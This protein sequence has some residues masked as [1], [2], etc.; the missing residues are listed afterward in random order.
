M[1][2]SKFK[3][4][5]VFS[6]VLICIF[7]FT[8]KM[9]SS[10]SKM[11]YSSEMRVVSSDA[12]AKC[13]VGKPCVYDDEVDLRIIVITYNRPQ[14][15]MKLLRT[16]DELELDGDKGALEIWIDVNKQGVV[17][18]ETVQAARSFAW[19]KGPSRVHIQSS[20]AGIYG[21]WIDTWRPRAPNS[22]ELALI[23]ED[24]IS[25]SKYAYRW[26]KAVHKFYKPNRDF[27]GSTLTSDEQKSHDGSFRVLSRPEN[28]TVFMYKCVGTWGFSP[29]TSMWADFQDWYHEHIGKKDFHPYIPNMIGTQWYKEFEA[30]GRADTMWEQWVIYY[31]YKEKLFTVYSNLKT[32]N[33]D[34]KS[35]L[36]INRREV[37]LHVG[38]KGR[39]DYCSLLDRWEDKYVSFSKQIAKLD[40]NG[41]AIEKY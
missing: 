18:R 2:S 23:L 29:R 22:T 37:G 4:V 1:S 12:K 21:Q 40:W 30:T 19:K 36:C 10:G 24:D 16:I 13:V 31:T 38:S 3:I 20:H 34:T 14:S 28:E 33:H 6:S 25:I 35:C 41:N 39:E 7:L 32:V 11:S 5:I 17:H 15:L 9:K 8:L 26:I 27:A